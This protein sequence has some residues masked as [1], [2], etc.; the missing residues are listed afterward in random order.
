MKNSR[1]LPFGS[2][3]R[4]LALHSPTSAYRASLLQEQPKMEEPNR[5]P[6]QGDRQHARCARS[7][8]G[9]EQ[10]AQKTSTILGV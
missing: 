8:Y 5:G 4:D 2:C 9:V 10:L 1:P 7:E 3:W 6:T